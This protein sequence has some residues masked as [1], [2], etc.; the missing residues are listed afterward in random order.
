[1]YLNAN[2]IAAA[3]KWAAFYIE[4]ERRVGVPR[5]LLAA[6]HYRETAFGASTGRVGGILQFD[7][8]LSSAR[9]REYGAAYGITDLTDPERD[10]RTAVLCAAA[11]VQAKLKS[12]GR[13]ALTP[14][15]SLADCGYAAFL[16]NGTGYGS[17]A[18]SPY[19][20]NDPQN[21]VQ[22]RIRGTVPSLAN[23]AIR[24]RIDQPDT[25]PGVLA[26]MHE[27]RARGVL[28]SGVPVVPPVL[29]APSA[30]PGLMVPGPSGF[31]SAS[32][33]QY[34][35]PYPTVLGFSGGRWFVRPA[36]ADEL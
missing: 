12:A 31:E 9:V 4:A 35:F 30:F 25:R 26:V 36:R 28:G 7:P 14:L 8:P 22:M 3:R 11:F 20:S 29:T 16:Y 27:L 6:L 24:V 32:Q 21:G 19:A 18:N 13:P 10:P 2:M 23:P 33:A 5:D 1:M 17:V 15:S 34:T